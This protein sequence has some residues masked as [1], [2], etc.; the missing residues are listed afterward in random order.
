M[1]FLVTSH[2]GIASVDVLIVGLDQNRA[3]EGDTVAIML[4]PY[5][6]WP[7]HALSPLEFMLALKLTRVLSPG[8]APRPLPLTTKT[9]AL[10]SLRCVLVSLHMHSVLTVIISF[11]LAL[12]RHHLFTLSSLRSC[13]RHHL[14]LTT[15]VIA[16][17]RSSSSPRTRM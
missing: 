1:C 14:C 10:K 9:S 16:T 5:H 17:P 3:F 11:C 7:R 13:R 8:I 15:I 12:R 2:V 6:K 4:Y